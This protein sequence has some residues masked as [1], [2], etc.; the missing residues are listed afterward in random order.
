MLHW[1][2][3][4]STYFL[5]RQGHPRGS[6]LPEHGR[7]FPQQVAWPPTS[8]TPSASAWGMQ[9]QGEPAVAA[10]YF[11]DGSTSE[12]DFH[13]AC[14]LAGVR[15]GAGD[16]HLPEQPVGDLDPAVEARP[17]A[18]SPTGRRLRHRRRAGRR[19]RPAGDVPGDRRRAGAG[20]R[21]RRADPDRGGH[22]PAR[23]PHHGRRPD[24]LRRPRGRRRG[25]AARPADP[26]PRPGCGPP[27]AGTTTPSGEASAWCSAEI[28]RAVAERRRGRRRRPGAALRQR[29]RRGAAAAGR[30][31]GRAA[32]GR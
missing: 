6:T 26:L 16:L 4:L 29:L 10:C 3:D 27:D 7:L 12:G 23:R 14:N 20:A 15:Q 1:G 25:G 19:Q 9:L 22:L 17:P 24:A 32:A 11:G 2:L 28:D 31:T 13:E 5:Q 8:P 30:P 21:R 18:S